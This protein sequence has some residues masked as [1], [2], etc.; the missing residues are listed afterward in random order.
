MRLMKI[1]STF[2][3]TSAL[4]KG[5]GLLEVVISIAVLSIGLLGVAHMQGVGAVSIEHSYQ[6]SQATVLAYD[7]A[8]RIRANPGSAANYL[9]ETMSPGSARPKSGCRSTT[10]CTAAQ[11]AENDLYEWNSAIRAALPAAVGVITLSEATYTVSITWDDNGDGVVG[12]ADPS[13]LMR[14]EL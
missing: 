9:T 12:E 4:Q 10:G 7:I 8:D 13:F 11:M 1:Q 2:S 3:N 6:R 14:F 5:V